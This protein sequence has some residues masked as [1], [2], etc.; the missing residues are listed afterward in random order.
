MRIAIGIV[1]VFFRIDPALILAHK[2]TSLL[3]VTVNDINVIAVTQITSM[4]SSV[5]R[6]SYKYK[7]RNGFSASSLNSPTFPEL[8][9]TRLTT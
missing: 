6:E 9:S 8:P 7:M 4:L 5:V 3:I 1:S 2:T